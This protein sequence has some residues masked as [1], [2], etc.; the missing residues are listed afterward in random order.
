MEIKIGEF[1]AF[2][3]LS[4]RALRL[5][6]RMELVKPVRIDPATGYRYYNPEQLRTVN[7][8]ISYKKVGFSLAEIRELLSP[9]ITSA[10]IIQKLK[11]KL[12]SNRK[13]ADSCRYHN[14]SIQNILDA[15]QAGESPESEQEAA[16][17]LSRIACLENDGLQEEFSQILWL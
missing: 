16:L 1:A 7:A 12:K 6:D 13:S 5:Y 14:E 8:I 2:C 9:E 4:V 15:Y 10:E 17:R 11:D 3:N